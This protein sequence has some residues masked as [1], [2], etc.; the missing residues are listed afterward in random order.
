MKTLTKVSVYAL[1]ATTFFTSCSRQTAMYQ[2][3]PVERFVSEQ[4][5][6][7]TE[8]PA[9]AE[10]PV[11]PVAETSVAVAEAVTPAP[12]AQ[13]KAVETQFNEAVASAR[14]EGK[15]AE[16]KKLEK[17]IARVQTMLAEASANPE[18]LTAAAAKKPNFAQRMMVKKMN[19][20]IA[21]KLAPQDTDA[22]NATSGLLR[23][24]VIIAIIG[25]I[26][27]FIPGLGWLGSIGIIVGLVLILLD[28]LDVA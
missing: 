4:P 12:A 21:K 14:R 27:L 17:R 19:N 18:K 7:R 11:A 16:S 6:V 1:F 3:Q 26:L 22:T 13:I 2:R 28:L 24:G 8:T 15:L 5:A 25:L 20:K 9:V 23:L 10:T